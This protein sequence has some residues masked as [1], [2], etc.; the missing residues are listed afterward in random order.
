MQMDLTFALLA[1][2]ISSA[3]FHPN[4]SLGLLRARFV[5]RPN[6]GLTGFLPFNDLTW[7][8]ADQ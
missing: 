8:W 5:C 1:T 3:E 6:N 7:K 4:L 2:M